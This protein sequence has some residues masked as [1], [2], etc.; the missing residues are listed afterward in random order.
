V[1][2][3]TAID[4]S[5]LPAP[6]AVEP[7]S[8]LD[9]EAELIAELLEEA[10]ELAP[11][12]ALPSAAIRKL[13]RV[14]AY[15]E[16]VWRNR[17]NLAVQAVMLAFATGADLDGRAADRGVVRFV[18]ESDDAFR[19]RVALAPEGYS[20]AGPFGAY[21]FHAQSAHPNVADVAV[22]SPTPGQARVV[23]LAASET[24]NGAASAA[25]VP[26]VTAAL[27]AEDVRPFLDQ[28]VVQAATIIAYDAVLTLTVLPGPDGA[29][30]ADAARA[31][32]LAY[33]AERRRLGRDV[34]L[35][36]FYGAAMRPGVSDAQV[37]LRRNNAPVA[38]IV[39]GAREAAVLVQLTVTIGG[40][41]V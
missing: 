28:V 41:D 4:L 20:V 21:L 10:P 2:G 13:V 9:I 38:A 33:A 16:T 36:G 40:V 34:R 25:L 23:V 14:M 17:I 37:E 39:V 5:K 11:A 30:A 32:A 6:A 1:S 22:D 15:R 3:F 12:L 35:A 29:L 26:A 31:A 7:L 8:H 19:A 24:G 27:R 18:G